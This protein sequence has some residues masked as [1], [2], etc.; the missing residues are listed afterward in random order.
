MT[1]HVV[2]DQLSKTSLLLGRQCQ[3]AL[4][5][6]RYFPSLAAPAKETDE[7]IFAAGRRVGHIA[8]G[9]FPGGINAETPGESAGV[10][11][12]PQILRTKTLIESGTDIIYE[13]AF[14]H[15]GVYCAVDILV[16]DG[17][18]WKIFEVKSSSRPA[19]RHIVDTAIQLFVVT[20]C[21]FYVTD[22][23]LVHLNREYARGEQLEADSL[24]TCV[25]VLAE[26]QKLSKELEGDAAALR[27]M[28]RGDT[29]PAVEIG[30]HCGYP[31]SCSF[32][33]HC[34]HDVA[35]DSVFRLSGLSTHDQFALYAEGIVRLAD[36]PLERIP[37][38][39][40]RIV[41]CF[42]SGAPT[43]DANAIRKFQE[44][45][46]YPLRFL[47][48]EAISPAIPLF[49]G[50]HPYD[51]IPFQYSM[52][53]VP[54]ETSPAEWR[55]FLARPPGDPR[56]SFALRLIDDAGFTGSIIVYN[57][58]FEKRV[59][60]ELKRCFRDLAPALDAISG[61]MI[62][63]MTV[64]K[65]HWYLHP[66]LLGKYGLKSVFPLVVPEQSYDHLT[67]QNGALASWAFEDLFWNEDT[68]G[69][70]KIFQDLEAYCRMDTE[71]L[72][73]IWNRLAAL[74]KDTDNPTMDDPRSF[75]PASG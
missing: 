6:S 46:E 4:Y 14:S 65:N 24:F 2:K 49:E 53:T 1:M 42:Q 40:Q 39:L 5:L 22:A 10:D 48:F 61:R 63:L 52:H 51:Q 17:T 18:G 30:P 74:T 28:L 34:W 32:I 8:R 33:P 73:L 56:H 25:S 50:S 11:R 26:A 7:R 58:S 12:S 15:A 68:A 75:H 69:R 72:L 35:E 19:E 66:K 44:A 54:T 23:S 71:A 57:A 3:K 70:E 9:L 27:S 47:D 21:G 29:I 43:F 55:Q 45:A 59:I 31:Y 64:F 16:K 41:E 38:R 60:R 62:D 37:P 20:G 67:I 13:A 36:L